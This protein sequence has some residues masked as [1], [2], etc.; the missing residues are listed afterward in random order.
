MLVK[1][2]LKNILQSAFEKVGI[3]EQIDVRF[4]ALPSLG[5]FQCNDC[6]KFAKKLNQN[7]LDLAN[8][9]FA[10]LPKSDMYEFSVSAP[11]FINVRITNNG[12][13][14]YANIIT[15]DQN[16]GVEKAENPKTI[17]MDYG[18]ANVAKE[19]H[20]G[21]LRSPII[22]E[23]LK[24]LLQLKGNKVISDVHL[25]D[26]GLQMG[27][28]VAQL[29]ED[30]YLDYFFGESSQAPNI[31][32]DLLNEEYPKASARKHDEVFKAKADDYTLKIQKKIEPYFSAYKCIKDVSIKEIKKYYEKL[33]CSF[34]LWNGE[35]DVGD[36]IDDVVQIFVDK[37]LARNSNGAL[38]CDVA[39]QG[40]HI[41][42]PKKN[43]NDVQLYKNP[44]PPV[45]LK[46]RNGGDLYAT[47]DIATV[48]V[49]NKEYN[50]DCIIYIADSRQKQHFTQFMRACKLSGISPQNQELIYLPFGTMNGEDG[51]PFK[52]RSGETIKLSDVLKMVCSKASE[53]LKQNG[54]QTNG[55]LETQIGVSALKFG[56]LSNT[57]SKD[58][59]FDLDKFSA[60][61]GKTGPYIQYNGA[62]IKSILRKADCMVGEVCVQREEEQNIMM[63]I[64]R[65]L[66]SYDICLQDMSLNALCSSLYDLAS[67][68][69][70]LYTNIYILSEKDQ[71]R[72][73]SLL[74]LCELVSKA[75]KQG[76]DILA[77]DMPEKM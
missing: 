73:A 37:G 26:F 41:P 59:V 14:H 19:L 15:K 42:I 44:M 72:K 61:E 54:V 55:E 31:T 10:N 34:D 47:T 52:T 35:S 13:S 60:F 24:R 25:G 62:R 17:I 4:S 28:T 69:A 75:L 1:K 2:E 6:F 27:L 46:K 9:V 49:R 36:I 38:V 11:A 16:L 5:H 12:F 68:F 65:L 51:K 64:F 53:R 71:K 23:G 40:E 22:G 45:L 63:A 76:L 20:M 7:P 30:G 3:T 48:F 21:H 50:P 70:T 57:I 33:N 66:D 32:L 29:H 77:I 39:M 56:D 8:Q 18:G 43:E 74:G 58:Y 67:S